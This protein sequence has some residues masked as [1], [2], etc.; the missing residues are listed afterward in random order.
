MLRTALE[1]L[2][3][4]LRPGWL[5]PGAGAAGRADP[6]LF[7]A[8][9][10]SRAAFIAQ[11]TILDY[12]GVKFGVRWQ[13]VQAD[14]GFAAALGHCRWAVFWP[15]AADLTL[16]AG[17]WLLPHA[18]SAHDL[19]EALAAEGE[20]AL[21]A[22]G[23]TGDPAAL[24]DAQASLRARLARLP[25]EPPAGPASM[26]LD[27]AGP[28]MET[29]P[30]HPDQRRG[31]RAAILGGLRMNLV[32]VCQDMERLFDAAPLAAALLAATQANQ[33][34]RQMNAAS[35]GGGSA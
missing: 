4:V 17:R 16:A 18:A 31:E 15:A 30:I 10:G 12:C 33:A 9:L 24:A 1:R 7:R 5:G 22:S 20:A 21:A 8:F 27:A 2:Q 6:A 29:I 13:A 28:L 11:K 19:A 14:P 3:R 34:A 35:S 32:A 25:D 23:W 26:A